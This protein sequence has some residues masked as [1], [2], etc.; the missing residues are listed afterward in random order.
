VAA[1]DVADLAA[2]PLVQFER[3]F[4]EARAVGIE[5]PEAAALATATPAGV[6]SLRMVLIKAFDSRGFAFFTNLDSRKAIELEAN[7]RAALLL[8]WKELSRQVRLEGV[9]TDV[10]REEVV[11]HAHRRSRESQLSALAS[12]QSEPVPDRDWLARRVAE[13]EREHA[14]GEIPVPERWG[15]YRLVPGAYEFWQS[16][17][18]RLHDRFRYLPIAGGGWRIERLAP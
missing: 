3:W 4:E 17:A 1:L 9:V 14:R 8:H 15:G 11:A 10:N 2:D 6:P 13:L 16:G 5:L 7:P 18:H 12:P